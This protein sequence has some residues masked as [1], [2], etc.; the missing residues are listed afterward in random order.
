[1][2]ARETAKRQ[3][4]SEEGRAELQPM[5]PVI[6]DAM[7]GDHAPS[8][9]V[10][11]AIQA[12]HTFGVPVILVGHEDVLRPLV[13]VETMGGLVQIHHAPDMVGM[14]DE[15]VAA[16]RSRPGSSIVV[17]M[18]LLRAG[19]G[20]AVV[21]AG[22][23]G[24]VVSAAVLHLGRLPG[25]ERPGLGIPFPTTV[26][27]RV[28]VIDAG[29]VVDP[30]PQWLVQQAALAAGYVRTVWGVE[31]PRIGLL[32]NGAEPEKGNR[33]VR[34]T[35]HLLAQT[36]G[37]Q[38]AGNIEPHRIPEGPVDV[39]VCD[40]FTGNILLKTAE[41]A[42]TLIQRVLRDALRRHWYTTLLGLML[43]PTLRREMQRLDYRSY[44]GVPLLGVNGLVYVAHGR[45]DA[46]ALCRAVQAAALA[47]RAGLFARLEQ[48]AAGQSVVEAQAKDR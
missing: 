16:V 3:A 9:P 10:Q 45:S 39:V 26:G 2:Q 38:F 6:V 21:S 32:S 41:G 48:I 4:V 1:M 37:A 5:L 11:G 47:A 15:A 29:A 46:Y 28:L 35:H 12:A 40:G 27:K 25:I 33:L 19:Q 31:E 8:A 36:F 34:E 7:G 44:G 13:G 20:C 22:H 18:E 14:G 17:A 23:S 24:A 30:R 42:A 43:R